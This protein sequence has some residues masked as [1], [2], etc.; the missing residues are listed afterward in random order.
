MAIIKDA[1][2]YSND[3]TNQLPNFHSTDTAFH[4]L[5]SAGD[6][7][8][9]LL[10]TQTRP[11]VDV[12]QRCHGIGNYIGTGDKHLKD[13]FQCE[14]SGR[15]RCGCLVLFYKVQ[16]VEKAVNC[17]VRVLSDADLD[18]SRMSVFF[19]LSDVVA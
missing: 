8:C 4:G 7:L 5:S 19:I 16:A 1:H 14:D 6:F 15:L 9:M 2:I 18:E 10:Q 11:Y 12:N 3:T 17:F 13:V